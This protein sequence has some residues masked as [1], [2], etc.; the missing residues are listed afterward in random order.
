M[1]TYK[2]EETGFDPFE[3]A[4]I[5]CLKDMRRALHDIAKRLP[6]S[7]GE[8]LEEANERNRVYIE[9]LKSEIARL[10]QGEPE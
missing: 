7:K 9:G 4:I 1:A 5:K 3:A 10:K 2:E 6:Q 8:I